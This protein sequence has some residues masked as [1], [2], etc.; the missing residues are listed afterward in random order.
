MNRDIQTENKKRCRT[1]DEVLANRL[2]T[3]VQKTSKWDTFIRATE[4]FSDDFMEE[5]RPSQALR[6][7]NPS[8]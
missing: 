5:G 6:E 4:M 3:E 7:G 1:N 8:K 2:E